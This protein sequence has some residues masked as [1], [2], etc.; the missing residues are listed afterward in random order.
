MTRF[1]PAE[2]DAH[3]AMWVGFPSH[4]NLWQEDLIPAQ[5]E[6][7]ALVRALCE[8]GDEHVRLMVMG[9][10]ARAAAEELLGDLTKLE[11]I[12]GSFE[13]KLLPHV[14]KP[15]SVGEMKGLAE[16]VEAVM[17]PPA[18]SGKATVRRCPVAVR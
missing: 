18:A 8:L 10:E 1:V 9:A 4:E 3:K 7:A 5:A 11:I 2:W 15:R 16:S 17:N 14:C 6:V 12:D 13:E